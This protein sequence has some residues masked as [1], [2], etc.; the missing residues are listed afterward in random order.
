MIFFFSIRHHLFAYF[1][2]SILQC[3]T[4]KGNFSF[5][6][7]RNRKG[8]NPIKKKNHLRENQCYHIVGL[9]NW[10]KISEDIFNLGETDMFREFRSY[11]FRC[12]SLQLLASVLMDIFNPLEYVL[13]NTA[14]IAF[15]QCIPYILFSDVFGYTKHKYNL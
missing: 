14:I 1:S 13:T 3:R 9:L 12:Q 6:P 7:K 2:N 11:T 10:N 5:W 15:I 4:E 8:K